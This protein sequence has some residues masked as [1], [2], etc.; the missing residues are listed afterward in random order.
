MLLITKDGKFQLYTSEII[1][2][3]EPERFMIKYL[4]ELLASFP[5]WFRKNAVNIILT[6][7]IPIPLK[8]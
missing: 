3:I 7:I 5:C 6:P 1:I 2:M 4:V 8:R